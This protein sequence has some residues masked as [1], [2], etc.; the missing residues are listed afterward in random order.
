MDFTAQNTPWPR[1]RLTNSLNKM[2]LKLGYQDMTDGTEKGTLG[3]IIGISTKDDPDKP[4]GKRG[5]ILFEEFGKYPK[6]TDTWNICRPSVEDGD[7][8]FDQLTCFGTGGSEG[9]DFSGAED[10]MYHPETYKI[11]GLPNVFD[12]GNPQGNVI[13]HWGSYLAR[14]G[15]ISKDGMPDITKAL[16][17]VCSEFYKIKMS[18]SDSRALTQR[19]AEL[20]ITIQDAIMR[21]EGTVF[22]VGDLKDYLEEMV[23]QHQKIQSS[24]YIGELLLKNGRVE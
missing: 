18:S 16:K 15:C 9:A 3:E 17:E 8:A 1:M 21:T 22:P 10:M 13:F 2:M 4:R 5:S 12:K 7:F 23:P 24:H 11:M 14:K 6:V 20:A 19:K